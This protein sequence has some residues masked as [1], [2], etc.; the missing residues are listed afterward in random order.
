MSNLNDLQIKLLEM[1][2]FFHLFCEKHNL[3]YYIQGGTMLGAVRHHGFIPW[4]DDIDVG[5]PRND[6]EKLNN[7]TGIIEGK[8]LFET[9]Y[10]D[11]IQYCLPFSKLYDTTT[12]LIENTQQKT[13][14]GI[15]ID[16]FPLDGIGNDEREAK[17]KYRSIQFYKSILNLRTIEN[18]KGRALYKN[19][20]ISIVKIIPKSIISEK[21]VCLAI[22]NACKRN[23][24]YASLW[25]GNLIGAWGWKEVMP[26][27]IY[28][29]PTLY[30]FEDMMVYGAKHY[31]EYLTHLYGNWRNL[32]PI[33]KRVS[34]HDFFVDLNK[35]YLV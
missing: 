21:K 2:R 24:F 32:P 35:S 26:I 1:L 30:Q 8:Y 18:R 27:S 11:D 4:D 34:H 15:Y 22:N 6:Y 14:R 17:K 19:A 33:D 10:S 20:A 28:G 12:T 7:F 16:I 9:V 3:T 29:E 5:M 23:D 25:G 31:D 13:K